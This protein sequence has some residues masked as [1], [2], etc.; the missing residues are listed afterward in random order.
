MAT[1]RDQPYGDSNFIVDLGA[2]HA[3]AFERV[4]L[5][6]LSLEVVEYRNG[7]DPTGAARKLPA[8]PH[9]GNAILERGV[10]GSLDLYQW[11]REAEQVV[12]DAFRDVTITLLDEQ[13]QAVLTWL[14][15]RAFPV[16]LEFGPLN[17]LGSSA[18]IERLELACERV[19]MK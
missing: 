15:V 9:Y 7:T 8:R 6:A 4:V 2:G 13:R 16:R 5:P 18:L 12:P 17:A 19:E 1:Q 10:L 11:W 3:N 14:L